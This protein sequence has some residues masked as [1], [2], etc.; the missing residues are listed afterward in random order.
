[1]A[2]EKQ[3]L[4]LEFIQSVVDKTDNKDIPA[5]LSRGRVGYEKA[6]KSFMQVGQWA[7]VLSIFAVGVAILFL[8]VMHFTY[9]LEDYQVVAAGLAIAAN[10]ASGVLGYKL[11]NLQVTPVFAL[12]AL[13]VI[14]LCNACI[15]FGILPLI[16]VILDIIA[17]SRY[18]TF[19]S[20]WNGL[21]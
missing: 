10:V 4:K 11:W 15:C 20:W 3:L 16:V 9:Y 7:A 14:L 12:V 21:K 2:T 13:V 17:L 1:M 5:K 6:I 19:C 18:G 8:V